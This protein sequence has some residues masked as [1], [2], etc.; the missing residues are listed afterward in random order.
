M[1]GQEGLKVQ[2]KEDKEKGKLQRPF[3]ENSFKE[4]KSA[5]LLLSQGTRRSDCQRC[6]FSFA[7]GLASSVGAFKPEAISHQDWIRLRVCLC[8]AVCKLKRSQVL[9]LIFLQLVKTPSFP[10][11]LSKPA[12]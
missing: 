7:A 10:P 12:D 8:A 11:A 4:V 9:A 1:E 5:N 3:Q 2:E 6:V